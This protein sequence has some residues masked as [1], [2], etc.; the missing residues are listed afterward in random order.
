MRHLSVLVPLVLGV[1]G[2]AGSLSGVSDKKECQVALALPNMVCE[3]G[4]PIRVRSALAR[5]GGV[6]DVDVDFNSKNA[7]VDAAFP[8]CS[9]RGV[10]EMLSALRAKGYDASF[11]QMRAIQRIE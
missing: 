9:R 4:C 2:C 6:R 5:V 10:E 3:E 11:V 8:A 1:I 7:I